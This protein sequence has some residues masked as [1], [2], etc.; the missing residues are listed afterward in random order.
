MIAEA[1]ICQRIGNNQGLALKNGVSAERNAAGRFSTLI[2]I[3]SN[4]GFK[5]LAV[6]IHQA[7]DANFSTSNIADQM[8]N[9]VVRD[10]RWA[11]KNLETA[12][13]RQP[14]GL[15]LRN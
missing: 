9:I 5:P 4:T 6:F 15:L 13:F 3:Q 2:S 1:R 12:K 8:G 11:V 10:F 7:D 14:A